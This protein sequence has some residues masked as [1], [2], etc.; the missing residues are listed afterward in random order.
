MKTDEY[1]EKVNSFLT[2]NNFQKLTKD[3]TNKYHKH[4]LKTMQQCNLLIDKKHIEYLIQKNPTH[5]T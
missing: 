1:T 2:H 5:P 3:P 4:L